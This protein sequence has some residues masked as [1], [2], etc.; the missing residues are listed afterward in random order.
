MKPSRHKHTKCCQRIFTL[1]SVNAVHYPSKYAVNAWSGQRG[2]SR[3]LFSI[4]CVHCCDMVS[5]SAKTKI[6]SRF[7]QLFEYNINCVSAIIRFKTFWFVPGLSSP[8]EW[9]SRHPP[10]SWTHG[11]SDWNKTSNTWVNKSRSQSILPHSR[12][13]LKDTIFNATWKS[14]SQTQD[15]PECAWLGLL[16]IFITPSF[17]SGYKILKSVFLVPNTSW[18]RSLQF[19]AMSTQIVNAEN[20][21]MRQHVVLE[22]HSK[23]GFTN[24]LNMLGKSLP[25]SQKLNFSVHV[26]LSIRIVQVLCL[27]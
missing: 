9:S 3:K 5:M 25:C 2:A 6:F 11:N 16:K 7:K 17:I 26:L 21:A 8:N 22:T 23:Y 1:C 10:Q 20:R 15:T 13:V 18:H 12:W 14:L 19:K 27:L 4:M 24:C